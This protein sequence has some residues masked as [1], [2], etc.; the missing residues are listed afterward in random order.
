MTSIL[1]EEIGKG[2]DLTK[3]VNYLSHVRDRKT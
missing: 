1:E 3:V 2:V